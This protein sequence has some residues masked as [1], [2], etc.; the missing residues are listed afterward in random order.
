VNRTDIA[1]TI[2]GLGRVGSD[3]ARL[4]M[5]RRGFKVV[6]VQSRN[7]NLIGRPLA[8]AVGFRKGKS[9]RITRDLLTALES[10]PDVVVIATTSFMAEVETDI[11][12]CIRHGCNVICTAEELAFPWAIDRAAAER[13][14]RFARRH[15]VTVLGAGANPGF[16]TDALVLTLAGAAWNVESIQTR[17]VVTLAR[18][19]RT[20]LKRLGVGYTRRDF[21]TGIRQERIFGHIGFPESFGIVAKSLGKSISQV[22]KSYEPLMAEEE[23]AA[24]NLTVRPGQTAGFIQRSEA[25][26]KG[27]VW[28]AA[29]F[30]GH[31][32]PPAAGYDLE[33]R[34]NIHGTPELSIVVAPG[35]DPQFTSA[36][37][38]ANSITR[39]L[40]APPGLVTV[41]DLRPATPLPT[42]LG[43]RTSP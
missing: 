39:V 20:V 25:I 1:V 7:P 32:N 40:D 42:D 12:T 23:M 18:F 15:G 6:G 43:P 35:F 16:I 38:V 29:E 30:V 36:G 2:V 28:F 4:L 13:L 19:S 22:R 5:G 9:V 3:V 17:R 24:T 33:D 31:I 27:K 8:E 21:T 37:V 41:A 10:H 34:I 11:R 26:V 14:D